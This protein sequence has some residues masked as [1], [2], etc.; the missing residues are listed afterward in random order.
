MQGT[1]IHQKTTKLSTYVQAVDSPARIAGSTVSKLKEPVKLA[2]HST[3]LV[4][5]QLS[6]GD[7]VAQCSGRVQ[8]ALCVCMQ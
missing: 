1:T 4:C 3:L 6:V 5:L 8:K 7:Q 2:T